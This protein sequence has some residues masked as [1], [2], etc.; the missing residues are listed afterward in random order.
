VTSVSPRPHSWDVAGSYF[1]ACNCDAICPCRTV[2]DRAGGRSTH[3]ICQFALSW[4]IDK[5]RADDVSLNDLAVVMAGWYDDDEPS[6]PWRV[7]LYVDDRADDAQYES[8]TAIF[9]GRAGGTVWDN[10]AA[11]IGT[12]HDMRRARITLSHVPRRWLIRAATYVS[13]S[14][15]IPVD[16]PAAVACG[17]P[18]LDRPGQEVIAD[19]LHVSD[20]PLSWD[21]HERC[22]FATDFH[23]SGTPSGPAL[24]RAD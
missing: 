23:Y 19:T 10:F 1:E 8:L 13:V 2:G 21:L 15:T 3:G 9:L 7:S 18:G 17:I 24:A 6:S 12:V 5:G 14:A 11:A 16:A 4:L 22:G 20:P